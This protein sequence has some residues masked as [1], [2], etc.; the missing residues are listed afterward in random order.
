MPAS[1]FFKKIS[2]IKSYHYTQFKDF[3]EH[4]LRENT[5][6]KKG[7]KITTLHSLA[8]KMGYKSPS[9]LSMFAK[10]RRLP[11][12]SLMEALFN[13]WKIEKRQRELVSLRVEI[14]KKLSKG[15]S[16]S[17]L[18]SKL[19]KLAPEEHYH[20]IDIDQFNSIRD[21]Y[22]LVLRVL[23]DTPD[24][25]EDPAWISQRLR[26]KIT[27]SQAQKG[28]ELL[29]KINLIERN[30]K[31]GKL[32]TTT[33]STESSHDIPSEAIR[34]HHKG[35]LQ[36]A[37]ESVDEQSVEQRH[38]NSLTFKFDTERMLEAKEQ[39]MNFVK[40]FNENFDSGSSNSVYQLNIQ[41]FEHTKKEESDHT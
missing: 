28:L 4:Q 10:G 7:K 17:P 33:G 3:F 34:E 8:L 5:Y 26:K 41:L 14:E 40:Q 23:V 32:Q 11:S 29:Q 9:L 12:K 39:I 22:I 27:P 2:M 13:E 1:L 35:M 6:D 31:S 19:T 18:L 16:T 15:K 30:P 24:F 25:N 36:K 37:I 38:L 20:L 21:W